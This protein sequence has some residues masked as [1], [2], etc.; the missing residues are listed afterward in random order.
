MQGCISAF[1]AILP[2]LSISARGVPV[3]AIVEINPLASKGVACSKKTQ[4]Y[5]SDS[6][7]A[8]KFV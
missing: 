6:K 2:V 8:Y 7:I 3:G 5:D 1:H 4:Q